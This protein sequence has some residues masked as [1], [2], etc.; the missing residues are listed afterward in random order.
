MHP[1]NVP[2]RDSL[3]HQIERQEASSEHGADEGEPAVPPVVVVRPIKEVAVP[4]MPAHCKMPPCLQSERS[5]SFLLLLVMWTT[6]KPHK[7]NPVGFL[8]LFRKSEQREQ[9]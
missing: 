2:P 4:L 1:A 3:L 5:Y 8:P 6:R 9:P 7:R